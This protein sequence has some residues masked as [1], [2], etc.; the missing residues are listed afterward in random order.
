MRQD[1]G[2]RLFETYHSSPLR[3]LPCG[4]LLF[5]GRLLPVQAAKQADRPTHHITPPYDQPN[6][7]NQHHSDGN[8]PIPQQVPDIYGRVHVA[9]LVDAVYIASSYC[10][11]AEMFEPFI[12][13]ILQFAPESMQFVLFSSDLIKPDIDLQRIRKQSTRV[14]QYFKTQISS[15]L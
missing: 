15:K 6:R 14:Q 11:W 5:A 12:Q 7:Q 10:K 13:S 2:S 9:I 3:R 4:A 1:I 8:L